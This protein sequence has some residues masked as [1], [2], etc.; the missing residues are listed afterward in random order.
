MGSK[1]ETYQSASKGFYLVL[2]LSSFNQEPSKN[3]KFIRIN[4]A[5]RFINSQ[6]FY[7]YDELIFVKLYLKPRRKIPM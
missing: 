7:F 6:I 5:R 3:F 4:D 2:V 1:S